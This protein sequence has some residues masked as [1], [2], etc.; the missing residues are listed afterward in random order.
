MKMHSIS[1]LAIL[2]VLTLGLSDVQALEFQQPESSGN[3]VVESGQ[4]I[5]D[6]LITAGADIDI[7]GRVARDLV[8]AGNTV[9]IDDSVGGNVFAAGSSIKINGRVQGDVLVAGSTV[10]LRSDAT[11]DG[12]LLVFAGNVEVRGRVA[13]DVTVYAGTLH[14]AGAVDGN[15]NVGTESVTLSDTAKIEGKLTGTTTKPFV[16]PEGAMVIGGVELKRQTDTDEAQQFGFGLGSLFAEVATILGLLMTGALIYLLAPKTVEVLR[17]QAYKEPLNAL[18]VGLVS[19]GAAPFILILLFVFYITLPLAFLEIFLVGALAI[20]AGAVANLWVGDLL[21]KQK[22]TLVN[23][24]LV[25]SIV[26]VILKLIPFLG[27]ILIFGAWCVGFGTLL[28]F[29][30]FNLRTARK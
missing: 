1:T 2:S 9:T 23:A 4:I 30:W 22:L 18:L 21:F 14:L 26:L 17:A 7:R 5:N 20:L 25:G 16:K 8:A 13:G 15:V 28:R 29:A 10:T 24:F 11:I 19:L 6:T 3:V 27:W 12:D